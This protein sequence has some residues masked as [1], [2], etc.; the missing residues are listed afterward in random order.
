MVSAN[1]DAFA[2]FEVCTALEHLITLIF[3]CIFHRVVAAVSY[4]E[5]TIG[6]LPF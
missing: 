3:Y 6:M 4:N 1:T 5:A 2:G